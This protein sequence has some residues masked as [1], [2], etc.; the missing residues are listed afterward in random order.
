MKTYLR[1]VSYV[2]PYWRQLIASV[3]FTFL[4]ALF[5]GL[6]VYLTIPLLDTLFQESYRT[7]QVQTPEQLNHSTGV[8]PDWVLNIKEEITHTFND[9][10]L[11]GSKIDA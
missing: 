8:V 4:F 11:S 5:N 6:S 2:R 3:L 1:I 7:E 10:V 9:F